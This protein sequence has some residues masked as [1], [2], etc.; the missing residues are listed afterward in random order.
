MR[1]DAL[2]DRTSD[3]SR[4]DFI[5]ARARRQRLVSISSYGAA[6]DP[7]HATIWAAAGDDPDQRFEP[8]VE[9]GRATSLLA[10]HA[11]EGFHP[12][13]VGMTGTTERPVLAIVLERAKPGAPVATLALPQPFRDE[14]GTLFVAHAGGEG[15]FLCSIA[16]VGTP[17]DDR[18]AGLLVAGVWAPQPPVRIAWAVHLDAVDARDACW[19][20]RWEPRT[21]ETVAR[22][23]MAIPLLSSAGARWVLSL[24]HD[25]I[26]EPWPTPDPFLA[27]AP[28]FTADE[29]LGAVALADAIEG[30]RALEDRRVV[31][32]GAGVGP[33]GTRFVAL[34]GSPGT[35][36]TLDRRFV[37]VAPGE[38]PPAS[39][40]LHE[41]APCKRKIPATAGDHPLDRWALDH[42]RETGARHGQLVVVR[43]RRLAFARAYTF[44][45]AGYPVARLDDAMRLGSVSK[46]LTTAALFRAIDRVG[47]RDGVDARVVG[48]GLL[49]FAEGEG[50]PRLAAVTLRHLLTHDAGLCSNADL[51][52]EQP[53]NPLCEQ[54]L[55]ALLGDVG[56]PARPGWLSRGLRELHDDEA[57]VRTPGSG[58]ASRRDYSNEGFMLLGEILARLEQGSGEAYEATVVRALLVPAGVDPGARGCLL[59]AGRRRARA[60][61]EAPAHPTNPT[62]A[63]KR[64]ADDDIDEGPIVLAPYADNG[65]FI[66]GAA[67]WCV[68]LVWLARVL[69]ALGPRSD[70]SSLW[71]RRHAE[72]AATPAAPGSRYGHGVHL[73]EPGWWTLR[74]SGRGAPL[75]L[76][77]ERFHHNGRLEGG[78]ALLVHQV[79]TDA[80][81][82]AL[83]A[84]LSIAAAFN[85]LGPLYEDPHGRRLLSL[86]QKL[87]GSPGWDT[88]DLFERLG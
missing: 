26:L 61:R 76:R 65:P 22:P 2:W 34:Y 60:R 82:D 37:A 68:P 21:L 20:D 48:P 73:G 27:G 15:R 8:D 5:R 9:A 14:R 6:G 41:T 19:R 64:F 33:E 66:G 79:P 77:V 80:R 49:G 78:A 46:A 1:H 55:G 85:V 12:A 84:T 11:R 23:V 67:G 87:E 42:M 45:E 81:D 38:E 59:G 83:D 16:A 18:G 53:K 54:R 29:V 7:R 3:E 36:A 17:L 75:I 28:R 44:A 4:A 30:R 39:V 88:E 57:F 74:P 40:T 32:L 71:Q 25:R 86:V 70:G 35:E 58:G 56:S 63:R 31:A 24:W 47:L 43:G 69:A 10:Q 62:W 13:L 72:L 52:P 51:A 50:P